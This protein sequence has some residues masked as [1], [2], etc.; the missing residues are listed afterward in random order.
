MSKKRPRPAREL[1]ESVSR[2]L[3]SFEAEKVPPGWYT[4]RNLA[5]ALKC[6][7]RTSERICN[8]LRRV[9]QVETK[10]FRVFMA[11]HLRPVVHYRLSK[12]AVKAIGLTKANR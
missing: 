3:A 10:T 2:F 4:V 7:E 9:G 1:A 8:R 6:Q 5:K 12:E 11:N